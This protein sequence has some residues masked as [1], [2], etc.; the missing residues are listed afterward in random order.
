MLIAISS[1]GNTT[2]LE[3]QKKS[4]SE[5][6]KQSDHASFSRA[7]QVEN[8]FN[9]LDIKNTNAVIYTS[10][11]CGPCLKD[12]VQLLE[13]LN[14]LG[15]FIIISDTAYLDQLDL[16][17]YK[18]FDQQ[19]LERKGIF[20]TNPY[21]FKIESGHIREFYKVDEMNFERI[22]LSFD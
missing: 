8:L 20:L 3:G 22:V 21:F 13:G 18:F 16:K 6:T 7:D 12:K 11:V 14:E 19:V 4:D 2:Q 15:A 1:C 10:S 17:N 5:F 9:E